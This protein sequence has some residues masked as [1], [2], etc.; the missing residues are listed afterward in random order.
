MK[1]KKINWATAIIVLVAIIERF[2]GILPELGLT[3]EEVSRIEEIGILV[4]GVIQL[5]RNKTQV[6]SKVEITETKEKE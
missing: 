2:L 1:N 4:L 6:V 5:F 3:P